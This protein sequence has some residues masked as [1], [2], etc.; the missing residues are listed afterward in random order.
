[1]I[2]GWYSRVGALL[3]AVNM[4]FAFTLAHE[5]QLFELSRSGGWALELQGMFLFT[6]VALMLCGPGGLSV[7]RR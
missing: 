7:N 4:L 6:A 5:G 3:I 2:I 1:V